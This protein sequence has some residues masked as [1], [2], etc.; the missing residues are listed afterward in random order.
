M[1][2]SARGFT[3]LTSGWVHLLTHR[4]AF[5]SDT[6]VTELVGRWV[7]VHA[8]LKSTCSTSNEETPAVQQTICTV[9]TRSQPGI[10]W[11]RFLTDSPSTLAWNSQVSLGRLPS[12][13]C[14]LAMAFPRQW[15]WLGPGRLRRCRSQPPA[16]GG[17][18]VGDLQPLQRDPPTFRQ[19]EQNM[20]YPGDVVGRAK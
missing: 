2:Q 4:L 10:Q 8:L 11:M 6:P 18:L 19:K 1:L 16:T 20:S 15:Q 13:L 7:A 17:V 14:P 12:A 9:K 3:P 5:H